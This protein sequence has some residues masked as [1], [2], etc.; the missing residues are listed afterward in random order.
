MIEIFGENP[1]F[2]KGG[3]EGIRGILTTVVLPAGKDK[4]TRKGP[5]NG[6]KERAE[7]TDFLAFSFHRPFKIS[8]GEYNK[9]RSLK[10][11][12]CCRA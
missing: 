5:V 3:R 11:L 2:F 1:P 4:A 6:P 12:R 7:I 8:P 9:P 10:L